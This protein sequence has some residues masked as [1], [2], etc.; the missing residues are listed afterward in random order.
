MMKRRNLARLLRLK[1]INTNKP[2]EGDF[3]MVEGGMIDQRSV[4]ESWFRRP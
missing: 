1:K 2:N 4:F 3:E